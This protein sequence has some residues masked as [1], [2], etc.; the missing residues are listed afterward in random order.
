MSDVC[1]ASSR[2]EKCLSSGICLQA[3][4]AAQTLLKT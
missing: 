4:S 1:E 2:F 3:N